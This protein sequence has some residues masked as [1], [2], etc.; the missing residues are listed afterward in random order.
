M[1]G[2]Y[3][4]LITIDEM[5]TSDAIAFKLCLWALESIWETAIL[6]NPILIQLDFY[7]SKINYIK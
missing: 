3:A 4:L 2:S 7:V 5:A 1:T 6:K